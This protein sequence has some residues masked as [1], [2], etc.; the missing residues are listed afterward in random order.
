MI[1]VV[2]IDC[3]PP[4][5]SKILVD[6]NSGL[7]VNNLVPD[8]GNLEINYRIM[9][10]GIVPINNS[11]RNHRDLINVLVGKKVKGSVRL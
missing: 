5:H 2:R 4:V 11:S 6:L 7:R 8:F 9:I 3:R 1:K 10:E